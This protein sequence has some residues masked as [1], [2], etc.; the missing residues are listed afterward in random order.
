MPAS[1]SLRR[2]IALLL[3]LGGVNACGGDSSGP[4][5]GG[6]TRSITA[7]VTTTGTSLDADGYTIALDGGAAQAIG[8]NES[9]TFT[10]VSAGSHTLAL[11]GIAATA[12]WRA[13][14]PLP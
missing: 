9:R 10:D 4:G 3:V 12:R 11:A 13:T 7:A 6:S 5:N 8:V 1:V 2:A 14:I